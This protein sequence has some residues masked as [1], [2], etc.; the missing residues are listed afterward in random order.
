MEDYKPGITTSDA[1]VL[2]CSVYTPVLCSTQD[3][4]IRM[5][6]SNLELSLLLALGAL[7]SRANLTPLNV[8]ED[9]SRIGLNLE[10]ILGI[11]L[12]LLARPS[13]LGIQPRHETTLIPPNRHAKNHTPTHSLTHARQR[14]EIHK[15]LRIGLL[16]KLIRHEIILGEPLNINLGIANNF[17]ILDIQA[18]DLLEL[19]L[20]VGGELR[21]DGEGAGGVDGEVGAVVLELVDAVGVVGAPVLVADAVEGAFVARA[22][23][24][25]GYVAGVR[26]EVGG[27]GVGFPDVEF[28][29]AGALGVDVAL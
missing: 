12:A 16:A 13:L 19:A 2:R 14:T 17:P 1:S 29:A 3:P 23:V 21:H 15:P 20:F 8:G 24:E 25:A 9:N 27:A 26:G 10:N 5:H 28:V 6:L 4:V 11:T 18:A 7:I 22:L